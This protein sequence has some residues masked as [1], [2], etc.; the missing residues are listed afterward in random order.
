[1]KNTKLKIS[2]IWRWL[3]LNEY[4]GKIS[5]QVNGFPISGHLLDL[6]AEIWV[7]L[8]PGL[9][10]DIEMWIE[11]T[12]GDPLKIDEEIYK[13]EPISQAEQ[14]LYKVS[15]KV[16]SVEGNEHIVLSTCFPNPIIVDL[17]V[18]PGQSD[19]YIFTPGSFVELNGVVEIRIIE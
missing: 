18:P 7:W 8:T 12:G 6:S 5:G 9:E 19:N 1:V 10:V 4:E 15:G 13:F 3:D 11:R 17:E 16:I 14:T 2:N